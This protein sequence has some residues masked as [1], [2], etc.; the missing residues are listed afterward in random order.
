M[1]AGEQQLQH[2]L[3]RALQTKRARGAR[4]A[5]GN[6]KLTVRMGPLLVHSCSPEVV[7]T[8]MDEF[9]DNK[10]PC[11][12]ELR[13]AAL[14]QRLLAIEQRQPSDGQSDDGW[15]TWMADDGKPSDTQVASL[16]EGTHAEESSNDGSLS[17]Q[18]TCST[19]GRPSV[20]IQ[21]EQHG[22]E[23]GVF[24][25]PNQWAP[26]DDADPDASDVQLPEEEVNAAN[27]E[28]PAAV[29]HTAFLPPRGG[30]LQV[31]PETDAVE[32]HCEDPSSAAADHASLDPG[33]RETVTPDTGDHLEATAA[34][35]QDDEKA[36][37]R[38]GELDEPRHDDPVTLD[39]GIVT[40]ASSISAQALQAD[41]S[42]SQ[43]VDEADGEGLKFEAVGSK[44]KKNNRA[45]NGE[46]SLNELELYLGPPCKFFMQKGCKH[47]N[48]CP[49]MHCTSAA[50]PPQGLSEYNDWFCEAVNTL[51]ARIGAEPKGQAPVTAI[52]ACV[53]LK[54]EGSTP[55]AFYCPNSGDEPVAAMMHGALGKMIK[56]FDTK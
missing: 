18:M 7:K 50:S 6:H 8:W 39:G 12:L 36:I 47:G 26:S 4:G 22:D 42:D 27:N 54:K 24:A 31:E 28:D 56:E 48:N 1:T 38:F 49:K 51:C 13:V 30:W 53:K 23:H 35:G 11:S 34:V 43:I 52:K 15:H 41:M 32:Q 17:L 16:D 19:A 10:E 45:D 55:G 20:G 37:A 46:F 21:D 25:E 9:R 40:D 14:E 2:S 29:T 33:L 44:R 5:G 3:Q